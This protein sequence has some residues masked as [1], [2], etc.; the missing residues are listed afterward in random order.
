MKNLLK[1]YILDT[2]GTESEHPFVSAPDTEIFRNPRNQ[3]WFAVLLGQLPKR[4]LGL[5]DDGVADVL[6]LKCDPIMTFTLIDR[7]R[8]F[9][10]YHMNKDHWI[11]VLLD[12]A[13]TMD[14]LTFLVDLS[15]RLVDQRA[16]PKT[17]KTE[18]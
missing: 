13:I 10:A 8:I 11:S 18:K 1:Q 2:Y 7:Q 16:K 5:K 17:K 4:C 15:Y 9:R 6:N 14:E 3:K 12:S